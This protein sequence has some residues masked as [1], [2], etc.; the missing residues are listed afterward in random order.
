MDDMPYPVT[1]TTTPIS[2]QPGEFRMYGNMPAAL[3]TGDVAAER[4]AA[5]YPNP[6]ADVFTIDKSTAKVEI[7]S[8]TGQ[9]VKAFDAQASY[10]MF[11]VSDLNTG[12][13]LVKITDT[14]NRQ[15]TTKLI[16]K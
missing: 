14:E 2:L 15:S 8:V 11:D 10:Y 4:T 12:M 16:R 5:L 6:T 1:N 13:Y 7:Y 3:G 9:L